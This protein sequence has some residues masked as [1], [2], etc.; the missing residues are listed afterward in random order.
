M[1]SRYP[2]AASWEPFACTKKIE[3]ERS[4][5]EGIR[6]S[7]KAAIRNYADDDENLSELPKD[8]TCVILKSEGEGRERGGEEVG[9]REIGKEE[10]R[11]QGSKEKKG[12]EEHLNTN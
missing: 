4:A 2:I 10:E 9:R 12:V 5:K 11:E 8:K 7:E 1:R 3:K 6:R